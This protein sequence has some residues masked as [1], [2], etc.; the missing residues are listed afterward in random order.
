MASRCIKRRCSSTSSRRR[1]RWPK[2]RRKSF[3]RGMR[4]PATTTRTT[5]KPSGLSSAW[6]SA[7]A[8]PLND[9]VQATL[10]L[11]LTLG[12]GVGTT[13]LTV[14]PVTVARPPIIPQQSLVVI[15]EIREYGVIGQTGLKGP[16]VPTTF[17][18]D[19]GSGSGILPSHSADG[20][21]V[22]YWEWGTVP[23]PGSTGGERIITGSNG[24]VWYTPDHYTTFVEVK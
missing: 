19:G 8:V 6:W 23:S 5:R 7:W 21:P 13:G 1:S 10:P 24:S 11:L 2:L 15:A 22:T 17:A 12:V 20:Q 4:S 3:V 18:N 16:A 9:G 14:T